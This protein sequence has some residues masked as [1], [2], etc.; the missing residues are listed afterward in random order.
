MRR[1]G[2]ARTEG[3]RGAG[4]G[5][6]SSLAL[7]AVTAALLG[8]TAGIHLDLY[9]AYKYRYIATIGPLFLF[10]GVAGAVLALALLVLRGRLL[11]AAAALGATFLAAT[12]GGLALSVNFGLFGFKETSHAPLFDQAL[13]VEA[14]GVLTG[15]VL[16]ALAL[17]RASGS[18]ERPA[19]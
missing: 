2:T 1:T 9:D 12:I 3:R 15:L 13:G 6:L 11:A 19:G 5:G 8:T 10:T 16:A 7:R 18:R 17:R 14:A 4:P